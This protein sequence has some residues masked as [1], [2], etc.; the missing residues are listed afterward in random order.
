MRLFLTLACAALVSAAQAAPLTFDAALRLADTTAPSLLG[1]SADVAAARS[2]AIAAGRLPDPKLA[3]GLGNFP[4]SG[5]PAG[6]FDRDSMTMATVGVSQ[7]MP[8]N[9][10]RRASRERA[11]AD[12][13]AA[14]ASARVEARAVRLAASLAWIDLFYANKRLAALGEV[15]R[16]LTPL[17]ASAPS[18]IATG[19]ARPAL[20]LEPDQ[21][22]AALGDRR[23]ELVAAV[24]RARAELVRWTGEVDADV[25]GPPPNF[26]VDPASLR[27]GLERL[28]TLRAYD[29][30]GR[31]ADADTLAAKAEKQPDWS[32][33]LT[34]QHRDPMYGDM[35]SVGA[36][37]SLPL[38]ADKRQ[39]PMI[40]ARASSA[41]RVRYEREAARRALSA[42]LEAD[43]AD[44]AM[45]HDR[46]MRARTTL[47][48]LAA[49]RAELETASYAAGTA[50]LADVLGALVA[51]AEAKI[52][53]LDR[54]A[55]V[56]RDAVRIVQTYG[57]D[58][59]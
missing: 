40:A 37:V 21:L 13:E 35:V 22:S 15:E 14:E 38:F 18:Q 5:P 17:R 49:R 7:D 57:S 4:I 1:R 42:T 6:T 28:P 20:A 10:K 29:A 43:L 39:D 11:A 12:I 56:E 16:A 51:L 31:Q 44:H 30:A 23:A 2:T 53:I 3:T 52:N 24:G 58:A 59:Q 55:D 8:S 36:S 27:A 54:E 47:E 50:G 46:L 45:H 25:T 48:P 34:Y 26:Q 9:A 33:D 41:A 19:S 32:W